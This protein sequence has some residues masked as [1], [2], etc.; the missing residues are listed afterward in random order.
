[1]LTRFVRIQLIIFAVTSMVGMSVMT[2]SYLQV[3]T[4]VGI[5]R[6]T[7]TLNL[8]GAGGLYRFGNVTYRGSQVG[9]VLTI[10]PTAQGATA[11]LSLQTTPQIPADLQA[12]VRSVSAIGEQY[13]EL[14]PRT[15]S[16]PYL[17]DGSVISADD[18][19]LPQPVGPMLDQLNALLGSIPKES[20]SRLLDETSRGLSGAGYDLGSII[21]SSAQLA[22]ELGPAAEQARRL[23]EDGEPLLD[24]QV[25]SVDAIRLWTRSLA[26]VT[27]Q[28][29]TND[30][31]I[32]GLLQRGPAAFREVTAL[33]EQVRPTLPLL[34]ANL[35]SIGEV[36]VTYNPSL[37]Q[38]L[39]LLPPLTAM[40]IGAGP[41]NNYTGMGMGDFRLSQSDPAP[42]TVGY[43]PPNQWRPPSDTSAAETPDGLYCKLPQDSPIAVRGA[44]NYPCMGHPGKRAPTVAEC[45]SDEPYLPL[46]Q[47]QHVLGPYPLDPNLI[48]QGVPPDWRVDHGEHIYAPPEG[49][50]PPPDTA[51]PDTPPPAESPAPQPPAIPSDTPS[52][53]PQASSSLGPQVSNG[54]PPVAFARYD[55][56]TGKYM[57]ADGQVYEQRNLVTTDHVSTWQELVL[58]E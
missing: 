30:P 1:M 58:S 13:V 23:V 7:V 14:R 22:D 21:D 11:T 24:S 28:L 49:T 4:L 16:G 35:S 39:V 51:P 31:Q 37:E 45:D 57:A 32:R 12:E 46:A 15:N 55:P 54:V 10:E 53:P 2:F 34:L 20:T 3:P 9:K 19:T 52:A 44:R 48:A 27:T 29:T 17:Q 5:G 38:L 40:F 42:C 43:L 26:G 56:S 33:I 8:P 50:P 6:I 36:G 25:Q 41:H 18:T 47:R